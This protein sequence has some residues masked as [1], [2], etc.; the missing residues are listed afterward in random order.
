LA[1]QRLLHLL[2]RTNPEKWQRLHTVDRQTRL[3]P[4]I[5]I[6]GEW[7][8]ADY[9]EHGLK[10]NW[11][12]GYHWRD[13]A[14]LFRETAEFLTNLFPEAQSFLDAGC[15]KGF[16]VR[17]LREKGRDAWGFDH[18][19]W[20]IDLAETC[21]KSFLSQ[22]SIDDANFG[23]SFDVVVAMSVLESLTEEQ[24]RIFLPLAR[25]WTRQAMF[26]TIATMPTG[27]QA[28]QTSCDQDL[29]HITMKD[30]EWW[31]QRFLEAGWRQDAIHRIAE[32]SCQAATLATKMGWSVYLF[33]PRE[34][35]EFADAKSRSDPQ[36]TLPHR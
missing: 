11:C 35:G 1:R 4:P 18:S 36:T 29:S 13:F 34:C 23:K 32:R 26:A 12:N 7:Y 14:G 17:S 15:A 19:P 22:V 16:L 30:R 28:V 31:R 10:S 5:P 21:A 33:S 8:D 2:R 24:I 20:A 25:T 27:T 6:P 9:F 3:K